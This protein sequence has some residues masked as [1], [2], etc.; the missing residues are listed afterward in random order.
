MKFGAFLDQWLE[1]KKP[2][3]HPDGAIETK[4][5]EP[6]TYRM[7]ELNVRKYI[8]P[9]L[10]HL[11]IEQITD[12]QIEGL[13]QQL[14]N[15][16]LTR[17][18]TAVRA[19]LR[20]ALKSAQKK[21]IIRDNPAA[22]ADLPKLKK[23]PQRPPLTQETFD[24]I[25]EAETRPIWRAF[26]QLLVETGLRPLDEARILTW[27]E[28][29]EES[30]GHWIYLNDSKTEEG[31]EPIPI[32]DELHALLIDLRNAPKP[33][34]RTP[35]PVESVFVFPN[36][37]TGKPYHPRTIGDF[38]YQ[39]LEQAGIDRATTHQRTNLYELRHLFGRSAAKKLGRHN[40][41]LLKR[42]L[43]HTQLS[44]SQRYYL[45]AEKADVAAITRH[46]KK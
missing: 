32:T 36:P 14:A 34:P 27:T 13:L 33:D 3:T 30:D 20:T 43:R 26:W 9:K 25:L 10:G 8:K 42:L 38:W 15:D 11:S 39:A 16:G 1:T 46:K 44:T 21:R 35:I 29:F 31:L 41:T 37:E 22:L 45:E 7:Y 23:K 12:G 4:G 24:K 18:V 28:I 40:H 6:N 2:I 5:W 17:T 19:T